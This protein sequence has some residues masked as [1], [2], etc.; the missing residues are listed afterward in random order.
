MHKK[1]IMRLYGVCQIKGNSLVALR[2]YWKGSRVKIELG[3]AKGKVS[4][5]KREDL[6][7]REAVREVAREISR[8]NR[9]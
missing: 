5:D 3:V 2:V 9:R 6:K 1:E 7:K 8:F 4:T